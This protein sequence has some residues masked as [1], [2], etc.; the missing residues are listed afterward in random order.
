MNGN[1]R[2]L[3]SGSEASSEAAKMR[4]IPVK[5]FPLF[6]LL[7]LLHLFHPIIYNLWRLALALVH[8]KLI[9]LVSIRGTSEKL[10]GGW[11]QSFYT[12]TG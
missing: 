7:L 11:I 12:L 9:D 4:F 2:Q 6:F 3:N 10:F 8:S 1:E 5:I